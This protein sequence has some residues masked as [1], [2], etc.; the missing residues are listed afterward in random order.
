MTKPIQEFITGVEKWTST[1]TATFETC[2]QAL[3]M[4]IV[5]VPFKKED[6]YSL[7][8]DASKIGVGAVLE[9]VN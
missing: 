7:T 8:T 5:L 6:R 2:K 3:I 9:E 1:Q 4:N